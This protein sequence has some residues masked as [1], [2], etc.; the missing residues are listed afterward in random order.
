MSR[1]EAVAKL[2]AMGCQLAEPQSVEEKAARRAATVY[3][4]L[5]FNVTSQCANKVKYWSKDAAAKKIRRIGKIYF[6]AYQCVHC[7]AWHIGNAPRG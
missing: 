7:H 2:A 4:P 6:N 3:K 1:D 5:V